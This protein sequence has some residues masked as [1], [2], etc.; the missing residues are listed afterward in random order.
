MKKQTVKTLVLTMTFCASA[1]LGGCAAGTQSR[2]A[3][4]Q[5]TAGPASLEEAQDSGAPVSPDGASRI[6]ACENDEVLSSGE[7][8]EAEQERRAEIAEQYSVYVP[9]GMTYDTKKDRFFYN[10][11]VVRY[12]KDQMNSHETNGFSYDDGVIDVE[13]VRDASGALTGLK[14]SS[15]AAFKARTRERES[16]EN[17]LKQAGITA[18]SGSFE[19]GDPDDRD[20]SLDAYT[21]FGV[22][23]DG[24]S[25]HWMYGKTP[26]YILYDEGHCTFCDKSA[27]GGI[28]LKVV[29]DEDGNIEK[30]VSAGKEE[31]EQFVN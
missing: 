25:G 4:G 21:G 24:T 15:D 11:Q 31:L 17:E 3:P 20:D 8:A 5:L 1:A 14:Q 2:T 29:R 7:Q 9:Y 30:L 22:F 19:Q 18:E 6:Q 28:S 16:L 26:V 12:F 23:H 27:G 13:A 10:G